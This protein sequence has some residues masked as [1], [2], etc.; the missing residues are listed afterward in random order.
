MKQFIV[1]LD[2]DSQFEY[3]LATALDAH[4]K[5]TGKP[6]KLT[7]AGLL[8]FLV[9]PIANLNGTAKGELLGQW[10]DM[11]TALYRAMQIMRGNF[12]HGR[13][14]QTHKD[15][16]LAYSIARAQHESRIEKLREIMQETYDIADAI[17]ANKP[18]T[19]KTEV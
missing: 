5:R 14:Y 11:Y 8:G 6:N 15:P 9:A 13:D 7:V 19:T 4:Y 1:E 16:K 17:F 10:R 2:S 3:D 18:D 12:P